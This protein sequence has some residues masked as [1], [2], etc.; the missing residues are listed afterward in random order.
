[1]KRIV[2]FKDAE[3][4][5]AEV[6]VEIVNGRF[7]ASGR[8][9]GGA[10]Q[11]LDHIKPAD[12]DQQQLIDIWKKWH[13]NDMNAGTEKQQACIDKFKSEG[14][15]YNYDKAVLL[16]GST[17]ATGEPMSV[18]EHVK[19]RSVVKKA[20]D[21]VADLKDEIK[22]DLEILD[23]AKKRAGKGWVKFPIHIYE[24][25][26]K[27]LSKSCYSTH[28]NNTNSFFFD[29]VYQLDR[30]KKAVDKHHEKQTSELQIEVN[31]ICLQSL[32]YDIHP[33]TG[34]LYQYGHG[35]LKRGLPENFESDLNDLLDEIEETEA[36]SKVRKVTDEDEDLFEEFGDPETALA[37][38]I[39][40][41]IDTSEIDTIEEEG[42]NGWTVQ[43][44]GYLCGTEDEMHERC[45]EYIEQTLWAFN[46]SFLAKYGALDSMCGT[47]V[48]SILAPL[49]EQC[50]GGNDAVKAL[51]DWDNNADQITEDAISAD[52]IGHMLNSYDGTS[53]EVNIG[54]EKYI[55]C[56]N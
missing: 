4:N 3:S 45:K 43:G 56:Q 10:G 33:E 41:E 6:E 21:R 54:D 36:L 17:K 5:L 44:T 23:N 26:K 1:M 25:G 24:I 55:A 7:S 13:L 19:Y 40:L 31:E 32:L 39:M 29:S 38:A 35:W 34:E 48:E 28:K 47:D 2:K 27:V 49:R 8:Y 50:E 42:D 18:L 53:L 30:L 15:K 46:T 9:C 37:L 51:V 22:K 16:L 11:C 14:N 20:E 12:D 52:G